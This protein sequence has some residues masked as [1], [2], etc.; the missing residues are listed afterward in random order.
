LIVPGSWLSPQQHLSERSCSNFSTSS[1]KFYNVAAGNHRDP[2][3]HWWKYHI[4]PGGYCSVYTAKI[5]TL[6]KSRTEF[7]LSHFK[8]PVY[9]LWH[10][11]ILYTVKIITSH[12][13]R[14]LLKV[15][16]FCYVIFNSH[17]FNA[18]RFNSEKDV[19]LQKIL[20]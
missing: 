17:M 18:P 3:L 12:V 19:S 8:N 5:I 14:P 4:S 2:S 11:R 1:D 9:W 13:Y 10:S 16:R 7:T 20:L 15:S 6:H